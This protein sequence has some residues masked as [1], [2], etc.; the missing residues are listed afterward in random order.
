MKMARPLHRT[1]R[2]AHVQPSRKDLALIRRRYGAEGG[3]SGAVVE[4]GRSRTAPTFLI[5]K[6]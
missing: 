3:D 1:R 6:K 4:P 2:L 5:L